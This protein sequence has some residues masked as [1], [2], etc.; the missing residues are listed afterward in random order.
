MAVAVFCSTVQCSWLPLPQCGVSST[1]HPTINTIWELR[2]GCLFIFWIPLTLPSPR[3]RFH[4]VLLEVWGPRGQWGG[5]GGHTGHSQS[6]KLPGQP[7]HHAPWGML[8]CGGQ[9]ALETF[10]QEKKAES[11]CPGRVVRHRGWSPQHRWETEG[12]ALLLRGFRTPDWKRIIPACPKVIEP[13][14]MSLLWSRGMDAAHAA[15]G[16]GQLLPPTVPLGG[17]G[18]TTSL[19]LLKHSQPCGPG[20]WRQCWAA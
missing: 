7:F 19:L 13:A 2:H 18:L 3:L 14:G 4:R 6:Q 15:C 12:W 11:P 1:D 5:I 9:A 17:A 10:W 16:T 20:S 8:R